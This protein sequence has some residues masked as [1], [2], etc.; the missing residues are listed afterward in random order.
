MTG[1]KAIPPIN[2]FEKD[3]MDEIRASGRLM[4]VKSGEAIMDVG[5]YVKFV[6]ILISGNIKVLRPDENGNEILLYYVGEKETCAM[7]LTCCMAQQQ[8]RIKAVAEEDTTLVV[9]PIQKIE[10]WMVKYPSWKSYV[11]HTYS[12][13]FDELLKTID[14][15]AFHKVDEMRCRPLWNMSRVDP[16]LSDF[17]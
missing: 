12:A 4:E 1:E 10:E 13:R 15:I 7:S 14:S 17:R 2:G 5:Q 9:I 11:M 8:S 3:L 6:P 16:G